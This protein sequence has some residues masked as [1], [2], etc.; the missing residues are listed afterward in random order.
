MQERGLSVPGNVNNDPLS[1]RVA[2]MM[3][4]SFQS[5]VVTGEEALKPEEVNM[6]QTAFCRMMSFSSSGSAE[7]KNDLEKGATLSDGIAIKGKDMAVGASCI[8]EMRGKSGHSASDETYNKRL[9]SRMANVECRLEHHESLFKESY[10]FRQI[11]VDKINVVNNNVVQL[12]RTFQ[13]LKL[14]CEI[15]QRQLTDIN[16]F[17][18]MQ[19]PLRFREELTRLIGNSEINQAGIQHLGQRVQSLGVMVGRLAEKVTELCQ[20]SLVRGAPDDVQGV[21]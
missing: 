14:E 21:P 12:Q 20:L 5:Q 18:N 15:F 2:N 11:I 6:L 7:N 10:Q 16:N 3:I 19:T 1:R 9:E 4:K 17:L 8:S 13:E